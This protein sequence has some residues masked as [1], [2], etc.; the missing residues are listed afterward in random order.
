IPGGGEK[1]GGVVVVEIGFRVEAERF[2]SGKCAGIDQ[3]AGGIGRAAG[4]AASAEM[5]DV[6]LSRAASASAYSWFGPPRPL[7]RTVTVSS[8][9]ERIATRLPAARACNASLACS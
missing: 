6:S 3:R 1:R 8:P 7:P 9:P 2:H 4:T 5:P